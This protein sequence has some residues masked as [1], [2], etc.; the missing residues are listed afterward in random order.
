MAVSAEENIRK[1]KSM[2]TP[3]SRMK[4]FVKVSPFKIVPGYTAQQLAQLGM[5]Q[6]SYPT[7]TDPHGKR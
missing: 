5:K 4:D 7:P 2:F 1:Y 6:V 3:N